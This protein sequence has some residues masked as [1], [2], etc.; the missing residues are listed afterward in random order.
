MKK[1]I[2]I[3]LFLSFVISSAQ[4]QKVVRLE[5]L[6][7]TYSPESLILDPNTNSLSIVVSENY[8]GEFAENPLVFVRENFDIYQFIEAN[9]DSDFISYE[10]NFRTGKGFLDAEYDKEG[11]LL[12]SYSDFKNIALPYQMI[13][14]IAKSNP[15]WQIVKNRHV[16]ISNEWDITKE[17]YKVKLADGNKRK[18]VKI[19]LGPRKFNEGLASN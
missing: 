13:V 11:N 14:D 6:K 7:M 17:Y 12:S 10:V 1:I 18:N 3:V 8:A 5:E 16:A 19:D 9:A 15:G 4:A 2:L